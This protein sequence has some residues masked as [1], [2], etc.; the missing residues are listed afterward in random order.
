MS[1]SPPSESTSGLVT[2][3]TSDSDNTSDPYSIQLICNC[4]YG[5]FDLDKSSGPVS[6][7]QISNLFLQSVLQANGLD[8]KPLQEIIKLVLSSERF[9]YISTSITIPS[10]KNIYV[11]NS[12]RLGFRCAYRSKKAI[13]QTEFP[14]NIGNENDLRL[15]ANLECQKGRFLGPFTLSQ[16]N[17]I[18]D[19]NFSVAR[20]IQLE[21]DISANSFNDKFRFVFDYSDSN[22]N[23][24][25]NHV[26][27][28]NPSN[29]RNFFKSHPVDFKMP[30]IMTVC[31]LIYKG[32]ISGNKIKSLSVVDASSWYRQ[33]PVHKSA[34]F[35]NIIHLKSNN[36][37][38]FYINITDGMGH[39]TSALDAQYVSEARDRAFE[40]YILKTRN[41]RVVCCTVQDD[42]LIGACDDGFSVDMF[43]EFCSKRC[44]IEINRLKTQKQARDCT[45]NGF[46]ISLSECSIALSEKR[47]KKIKESILELNQDNITRRTAA[48][49]VGRLF[50]STLIFPAIGTVI[51]SLRH[52]AKINFT[53]IEIAM[54]KSVKAFYKKCYDEI[55]PDLNDSELHTIKQEIQLAYKILKAGSK[56]RVL[57][58][59]IYYR[60]LLKSNILHEPG[61]LKFKMPAWLANCTKVYSDA[62]LKQLGGYVQFGSKIS[63]FS[64][65]IPQFWAEKN[66]SIQVWEA[67][68]ALF[69]V[70]LMVISKA[71]CHKHVYQQFIDN[72]T[73]GWAFIA[74]KSTLK[75]YYIG[76]TVLLKEAICGITSVGEYVPSKMNVESDMLS[77]GKHPDNFDRNWEA[78]P[79]FYLCAK[80]LLGFLALPRNQFLKII[81]VMFESNDP[82]NTI[83]ISGEPTS[84][85]GNENQV[86]LSQKSVSDLD[87]IHRFQPGQQL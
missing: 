74:Y 50:S 30:T 62:S 23:V 59:E 42:T 20:I 34:F 2:R 53:H 39:I 77:R 46:H 84:F 64:Y 47:L 65:M 70:L 71:N 60:G 19:G 56:A 82:I 51:I 43:E 87:G 13:T 21:K 32:F 49:L 85:R 38:D 78:P 41:H 72:K 16:I 61:T 86:L 45:W 10:C 26:I 68:A 52:W 15:F 11:E 31:N 8:M 69:A 58:S 55:L 81:D 36:E 7:C 6:K 35:E 24:F 14:K 37:S 9:C 54:L 27:S 40:E 29:S 80:K 33:I 83:I 5:W 76:N 17:Y 75:S 66:L 67:I 28:V 79:I 25:K 1:L 4:H 48:K 18:F 22:A 57:C 12:L 63:F 73:S 44:N 3:E